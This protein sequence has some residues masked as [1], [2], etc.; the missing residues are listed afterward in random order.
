MDDS[1]SQENLTPRSHL[2]AI[3]AG[4]AALVAVL[5]FLGGVYFQGAV[6]DDSR[7]ATSDQTVS[8]LLSDSTVGESVPEM[9]RLDQVL[10]LI[11]SEYYG[12]PVDPEERAAFWSQLEEKAIK[13]LTS[14][15]DDHSTYLIPVE[16]NAARNQLNG[17]YE[18]IGVWVSTRDGL[19]EIISPIPGSP[20]DKAGIKAGDIILSVDGVLADV[21]AG[22]DPME[23][24]LG[25]A[26]SEV[27]LQ[28]KRTG[29]NDPLDFTIE[30]ARIPN[31][32]VD[33]QFDEETGVA[34]IGITVFGD[35]TAD[36]LDAA[37]A[38]A[39]DDDAVGIVLDLRNNGG[40]WV[41]SAQE[42]IGRFVSPESGPALLEDFDAAVEGDETPLPILTG[43]GQTWDRPV[44]VLVN[45]GTASASEIVAGALA[46]Y[47]RAEIIGTQTFGKGSVQRVH[48]FD[49]GSSLRLTFA[50]WLTPN[51]LTIENVGLTPDA[52]VESV[53]DPDQVDEQ[54]DAAKDEILQ[55]SQ[56]NS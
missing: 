9:A 34:R 44:V 13:G 35:K 56:S 10:D 25:P 14:G 45:Q 6:L 54:L 1:T 36:E 41:Q 20:A 5:A 31:P 40:G 12:L 51:Q 52:V 50:E 49:D 33:Y 15:L 29:A 4:V 47:D 37:I 8:S 16:Q 19:V 30:R 32:V 11:Q 39:F 55:E 2:I 24:L 7:S 46:D 17:T 53:D 22:F 28:I 3:L 43:D 38:R 27:D 23:A 21:T 18:G 48:D 26:G 42:T